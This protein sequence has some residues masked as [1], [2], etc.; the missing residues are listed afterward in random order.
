MSPF[1]SNGSWSL[2]FWKLTLMWLEWLKVNTVINLIELFILKIFISVFSKVTKIHQSSLLN[3]PVKSPDIG[4]FNLIF[5]HPC[6]YLTNK[7]LWL[8]SLAQPTPTCVKLIWVGCFVRL[9]PSPLL[10][11]IGHDFHNMNNLVRNRTV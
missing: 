9:T 5:A 7:S 2:M 1:W 3:V 11:I 6:Q 4:F 8:F 10:V